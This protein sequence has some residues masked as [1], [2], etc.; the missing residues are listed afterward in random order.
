M[1]NHVSRFEGCVKLLWLVG[2]Q[3][4]TYSGQDAFYM[5]KTTEYVDALKV[6][7]LSATE[8]AP[9]LLPLVVLTGPKSAE[10]RALRS[11]LHRHGSLTIHHDLSFQ[12]DMDSL[13]KDPQWS[14]SE[15]VLGSWLRVDLP[16]VLKSLE[17]ARNASHIPERLKA[18]LA[19]VDKEHVLWTDPDVIF[20]GDIDSCTLA[21]PQILSVGPEFRM[22]FAENY[23][24]IYFNVSGYRSA[25]ED[26][27]AWARHHHF[28]FDHDQNL[29]L[30]YWGSAVN[31]LPNGFNWKPYWGNSSTAIPGQFDHELVKIVH[32]HG[33]K[34]STASCFFDELDN[35]RTSGTVTVTIDTIRKCG[36]RDAPNKS[37]EWLQGLA[38]ILS[39]S[40]TQDG[41]YF[42]R[43]LLKQVNDYLDIA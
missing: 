31:T 41:G 9:S 27:I 13:R 33:P 4:K 30:G 18:E 14:F 23:G 36:L 22:G 12:H 19:A 16:N 40:Y 17:D 39:A 20:R 21:K 1:L 25:H 6:A 34:L 11:W 29:F 15:N 32:F 10:G 8:Y 38:D 43:Q 24:V 35:D 26:L 3:L 37:A 28:H 5:A 2:F 7:V 42:Y